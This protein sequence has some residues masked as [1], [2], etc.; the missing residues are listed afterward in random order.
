MN[1]NWCNLPATCLFWTVLHSE[2][3][4]RKREGFWTEAVQVPSLYFKLK[5]FSLCHGR[6]QTIPSI[7]YCTNLLH[8]LIYPPFSK[9][10]STTR[11]GI[12][13]NWTV[14][15]CWITLQWLEISW[16]LRS[17]STNHR[18][19]LT[20]ALTQQFEWINQ[21]IELVVF[22]FRGNRHPLKKARLA[23]QWFCHLLV[24]LFCSLLSRLL[25]LE[26]SLVYDALW[27]RNKWTKPSNLKAAK[28][29]HS[30]PE[31][32]NNERNHLRSSS[33][34]TVAVSRNNFHFYPPPFFQNPLS[35]KVFN[36][37][38]HTFVWL[39]E[40]QT[41]GVEAHG[42]IT[43]ALVLINSTY[44]ARLPEAA[45]CEMSYDCFF[46]L[47]RLPLSVLKLQSTWS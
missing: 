26:A 40:G 3:K 8:W 16:R 12:H 10:V 2:H 24:P 42:I 45:F 34:E 13:W 46:L 47:L 14:R 44:R 6:F 7:Q 36:D 39:R 27:W 30:K 20:S 23:E 11:K 37:M 22:F 31:S 43:A 33:P 29:I 15:I 28:P 1:L 38:E 25:I 18:K 5:N 21:R 41:K 32:E 35:Y 4:A 19:L 17:I 9:G